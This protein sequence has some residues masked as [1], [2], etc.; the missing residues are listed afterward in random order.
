MKKLLLTVTLCLACAAAFAQGKVRLVNDSLHL[1]YFDPG[2]NGGTNAGGAYV[3]GMGGQTLRI[4]LWSGTASGALS[5]VATTDFV[6]QPGVGVWNGMNVTLPTAAGATFF[7]IDIYDGAAGSY[8]VASTT[9]GHFYGTSGL[10]LANASSTIAYN[11][12]VNHNSPANSQWADGTF[13]LDTL[14]LG[15]RGSITLT[16]V[17]EPATIALAGLAGAALMIFRRRK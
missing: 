6:G 9:A 7:A 11:S 4:E 5:L 8:Q 14:A 17:P 16:Q 12:L 2:S 1:V 10:F 15:Y 13:N 3:L